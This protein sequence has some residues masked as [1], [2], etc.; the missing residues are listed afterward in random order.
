MFYEYLVHIYRNFRFIYRGRML[1]SCVGLL[2]CLGF[3]PESG[4]SLVSLPSL[5][6][7][8]CIH[9]LYNWW[10]H[11]WYQ[12]L[13]PFLDC[14]VGFM[15]FGVHY[16]AMLADISYIKEIPDYHRFF[17]VTHLLSFMIW[18]SWVHCLCNCVLILFC[19]LQYLS[20]PW[21]LHHVGCHLRV[22]HR[23]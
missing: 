16:Q 21:Q 11:N 3:E 23:G 17:S 6:N 13:V 22:W 20:S 2:G 15:I 8:S 7:S 1:G 5:I 18:V 19:L 12:S 10:V 14:S 9:F 4:L